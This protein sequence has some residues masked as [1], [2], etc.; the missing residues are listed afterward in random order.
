MRGTPAAEATSAPD[1]AR[2]RQRRGQA[3]AKTRRAAAAPPK[4]P[5]RPWGRRLW[6]VTKLLLVLI[7][8]TGILGTATL[9]WF[10]YD[11]PDPDRAATITRRPSLTVMAADGREL[12]SVG[13]LQGVAVPIAELPAF[14]PKAVLAIEDKRFFDHF[15]VDPI[16]LLRALWVNVTAGRVV[17]G[18]ST[19]TQQVAKNLF[20]TPER[21]IRRK[22]QEALLALWL[23]QKF[24]KPQILAIYLNRVYLGAGTYGVEAAAKRYFG[25][26]ARTVSLYEAAVLAGL[27]KAPSRLNPNTN[28]DGSRDRA[29]LVLQAMVDDGVITSDQ[30]QAALTEGLTGQTASP[31]GLRSTGL[32]RH[33]SDWVIERVSDFVGPVDRDLRVQTTLDPTLQDRAERILTHYLDTEGAALNIAQGAV[34][35][36]DLDGAVR[37][38]VGG[39]DRGQS[40]FNRAVQ[41]RRQPGSAFKPIVFLAGLEA[42]MTPEMPIIDEP[43][44]IGGWSPANYTGR[45]EGTITLREAL[46]QSINTVA[47]KVSERVGRQE[48]I[49]TARDLGITAP[50]SPAPS[51]ALGVFEMSL[52]ELT[53]AYAPFAS[54]GFAAQ[55]HAI[56]TITDGEGRVLYRRAAD[57]PRRV[58]S[59]AAAD[60]MDDML[61]ATAAW[62]TGRQ[63]GADG[64]PARGKSGTSQ[65]HRDAWF[66]GYLGQDLAGV[67]LGNDDGSPMDAVTGGGAPAALWR[68]IMAPQE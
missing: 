19:I 7:I 24:T 20:L 63:V 44:S 36:M 56:V 5:A 38:M 45:Y 33:F 27:P 48:V 16:G 34:V 4:R 11:L 61:R 12:A 47:V 18:G 54:G 40:G 17:Q 60:A 39:R 43:I 68:Q 42:G 21:T 14:L 50:L 58:A 52:L 59:Q 15:G 46:A 29:A 8:W 37:A 53:N 49:R 22:V 10:A 13:D 64:L 2:Q 62:G 65:A 9:A 32:G 35:I 1:A 28:P 25:H 41:A 51:L 66:I 3:K 23:E 26:G 6:G 30:Q 55:A 57:A 67:W 31:A